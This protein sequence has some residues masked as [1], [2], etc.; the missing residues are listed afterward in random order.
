MFTAGLI[1]VHQ[2][3]NYRYTQARVNQLMMFSYILLPLR[4]NTI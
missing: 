4:N 2:I 1:I 3:T